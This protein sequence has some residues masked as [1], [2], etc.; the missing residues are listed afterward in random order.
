LV[1]ADAA[2]YGMRGKDDRRRNMIARSI[3]ACFHGLA[4]ACTML[5]GGPSAHAQL[6]PELRIPETTRILRLESHQSCE[7]CPA[8]FYELYADGTWHYE[9][10]D[11]VFTLGE[12]GTYKNYEVRRRA[13]LEFDMQSRNVEAHREIALRELRGYTNRV[14]NANEAD[15]PLPRIRKAILESGFESWERR[16]PDSLGRRSEGPETIHS[17]RIDIDGK[18]KTVR[19]LPS[20]APPAVTRLMN[21]VLEIAE[22]FYAGPQH[23]IQRTPAFRA[24]PDAVLWFAARPAWRWKEYAVIFYRNDKATIYGWNHV[25]IE[26]R[27]FQVHSVQLT[28]G[29]VGALLEALERASKPLTPGHTYS[30][31]T[32]PSMVNAV[33]GGGAGH[34]HYRFILKGPLKWPTGDAEP[35]LR[36]MGAIVASMVPLLGEDQ[37]TQDGPRHQPIPRTK[38]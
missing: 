9:G 12:A 23:W 13:G 15:R 27:G 28:P 33:F 29:R 24:D 14:L 22:P 26:K 1:I 35:A 7:G 34:G 17:I 37:P 20:V 11:A 21:M 18:S 2:A 38:N 36:E 16:Y 6:P 3:A 31:P 10:I 30:N 32:Q 19:F 25:G 4:V 8:W 5:L